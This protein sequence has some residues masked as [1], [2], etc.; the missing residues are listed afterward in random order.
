V[1]ST[2]FRYARDVFTDE[3]EKPDGSG[4]L[5]GFRDEDEIGKGLRM[6]FENATQMET[7]A[8]RKGVTMGWSV[9][10]KQIV[11]LLYDVCMEPSEIES[12]K[13]PFIR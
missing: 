12:S 5:V 2:S 6:L 11:N 10:A 9:V 1:V 3:H 4:V 7:K 8:Y 13:I